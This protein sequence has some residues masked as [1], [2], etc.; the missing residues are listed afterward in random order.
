MKIKIVNEV[1][2]YLDLRDNV[3]LVKVFDCKMELDVLKRF[4]IEVEFKV[5]VILLWY[6]GGR[7]DG[8]WIM[9]LIVS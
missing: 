6:L 2:Y 7:G 3:D 4:V 8:L 9:V 1:M 5:E